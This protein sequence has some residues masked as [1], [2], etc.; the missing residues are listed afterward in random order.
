ML[1]K[2]TGP[3]QNFIASTVTSMTATVTLSTFDGSIPRK[4]RVAVANAS[5]YIN[6]ANVKTASGHNDIL[7][8]ILGVEHF[9]LDNNSTATFI[10]AV[11]N[12]SNAFVSFTP[13]A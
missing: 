5:I 3:S 9:T 12:A 6:F 11:P 1:S 4:V 13:V 10:A 2:P 8:P 7:I